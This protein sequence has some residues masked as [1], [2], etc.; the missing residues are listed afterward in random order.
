LAD[1]NFTKKPLELGGWIQPQDAV[2]FYLPQTPIGKV[3]AANR[4]HVTQKI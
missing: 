3:K 4:V 1:I 2:A